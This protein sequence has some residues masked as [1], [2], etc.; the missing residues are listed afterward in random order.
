MYKYLDISKYN[1]I[2]SFDEIIHAQDEPFL[3]SNCIFQYLLEK[4]YQN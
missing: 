4:K 3:S 1:I 2:E